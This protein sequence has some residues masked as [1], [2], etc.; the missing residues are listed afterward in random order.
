MHLVEVDQLKHLLN[1]MPLVEAIQFDS[2]KLPVRPIQ[3][4]RSLEFT[5][6]INLFYLGKHGENNPNE[7]IEQ[8]I[9]N[10]QS[11]ELI[12]SQIN[13]LD[14]DD[15]SLR[16]R[17]FKTIGLRINELSDIKL[18]IYEWE[19]VEN[20]IFEFG[21][22]NQLSFVEGDVE[23]NNFN[24]FV[25]QFIE[26]CIS[27]TIA[28]VYKLRHSLFVITINTTNQLLTPDEAVDVQWEIKSDQMAQVVDEMLWANALSQLHVILSGVGFLNVNPNGA[29][30]KPFF[31]SRKILKLQLNTLNLLGPYIEQLKNQPDYDNK[32]GFIE[33]LNAVVDAD[34]LMLI[35]EVL[36]DRLLDSELKLL[37]L[38]G[39][40][41]LPKDSKWIG[42]FVIEADTSRC[43]DALG[44]LW[45]GSAVCLSTSK[46]D[47]RYTAIKRR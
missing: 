31:R 35:D 17:P 42:R 26:H 16:R 27:K 18:V 47:E 7:I 19:Y 11:V 13:W 43:D 34:H 25:R 33:V 5:S 32:K 37:R 41:E 24:I 44:G 10:R 6:N 22:V 40:M 21:C 29:S 4:I 45:E 28:A 38:C 8:F 30:L 39:I 20:I 1:Y 23:M 14:D 3:L 15:Q 2:A 36:I 12:A 9:Y 46:A